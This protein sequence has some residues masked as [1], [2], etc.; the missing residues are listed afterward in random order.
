M[1]TALSPTMLCWP[2]MKA[3]TTSEVGSAGG[4]TGFSLASLW[5]SRRA[6]SRRAARWAASTRAACSCATWA[7]PIPSWSCGDAAPA[8]QRKSLAHSCS[9]SSWKKNPDWD[10]LPMPPLPRA[11]TDAKPP[12]RRQHRRLPFRPRLQSTAFCSL[13]RRTFRRFRA[14]KSSRW[15]ASKIIM[16][17][18]NIKTHQKHRYH[19][20]D[21]NYVY[22]DFFRTMYHDIVTYYFENKKIEYIRRCVLF[23]VVA[24]SITYQIE[25]YNLAFWSV[26][27]HCYLSTQT[28]N[29]QIR[30]A[31][32]MFVCVAHI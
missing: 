11:S 19:S 29:K 1:M 26:V 22:I 30:D 23:N 31:M 17:S 14:A 5:A 24:F 8:E 20:S 28:K 7:L 2:R 21:R 6:V 27:F 4:V 10:Y 15:C 13:R 3:S 32:Y 25:Q 16:F 12:L 18:R 9:I